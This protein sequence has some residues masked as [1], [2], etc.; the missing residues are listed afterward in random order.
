MEPDVAS[1]YTDG[2]IRFMYNASKKTKAIRRYMEALVLHTGA[3]TVHWE[4]ITSFIYVVESKIVTVRV[5]RIDILVFYSIFIYNGLFVPKYDK[6]SVIPGIMCTKPCSGTIIS[7]STK[8][9]T[10]FIYT[11][12]VILNNISS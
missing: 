1:Y 3:P 8:W 7:Q 6:Y 4:Y 9:I 5:K 12:P 11:H 2:E 10:G